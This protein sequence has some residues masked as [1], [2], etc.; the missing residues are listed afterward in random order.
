L[1][2]HGYDFGQ[3][4]RLVDVAATPARDVVGKELQRHGRNQR[5]QERRGVRDVDDFLRQS[6]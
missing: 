3:V 5:L 1:L 6:L 2:F 4:P